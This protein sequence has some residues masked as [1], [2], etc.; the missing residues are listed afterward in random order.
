MRAYQ[1]TARAVS[2]A[3]ADYFTPGG[4]LFEP[5]I[6]P[7]VTRDSIRAFIQSFPGVQVDS[8]TLE[9]DEVETDDEMA[10][11]WGHYF[12]M[13]RFPGQPASAQRGRFVM[14]WRRL[15]DGMWYIHRYYRIPLPDAPAGAP[16]PP[17][18]R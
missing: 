6:P 7:I 8:A 5:G 4:T 3:G 15:D 16:P 14:Q 1:G 13:L 12:E 11:V 10:L 18:P 2:P 9:A 17:A